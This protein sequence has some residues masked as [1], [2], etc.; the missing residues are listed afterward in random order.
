MIETANELRNLTGTGHRHV[1]GTEED[2]S[3]DDA[4]LVA[5]SGLILAAWLLKKADP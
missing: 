2:L 5:S 4:S 1:V 3:V